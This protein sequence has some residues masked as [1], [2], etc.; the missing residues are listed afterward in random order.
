MGLDR[1]TIQYGQNWAQLANMAVIIVH[2]I[3]VDS[4]KETNSVYEIRS[5]YHSI[6]A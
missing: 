6:W 1:L 4:Y 3:D 5:T 2:E